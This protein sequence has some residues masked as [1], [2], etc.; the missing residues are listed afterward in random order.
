VQA[1]CLVNVSND[2]DVNKTAELQRGKGDILEHQL[3][4]AKPQET[5]IAGNE[6]GKASG[7]STGAE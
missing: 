6:I 5:H 2:D 3:E 7:P 1:E 4:A